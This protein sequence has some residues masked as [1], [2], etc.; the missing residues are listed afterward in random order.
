[1]RK[2]ELPDEGVSPVIGVMLMIV[3][4]IIIAAVVSAFA[5]GLSGGQ[6]K[7]PV[8]QFEMHYF[9]HLMDESTTFAESYTVG[10][11]TYKGIG[12][13]GYSQFTVSLKSGEPIP[14]WDLKLVFTKTLKDGT[15]LRHEYGKGSRAA[16]HAGDHDLFR[17]SGNGRY[18]DQSGV[19]I[20]PGEVFRAYDSNG[21]SSVLGQDVSDN[22]SGLGD[23]FDV[24]VVH[25]P[26][27]TIISHQAVTIE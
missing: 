23:S 26:T 20:H 18:W 19:I 21:L 25:V 8:A 2:R 13:G 7:V 1:M 12:S 22:L 5:G 16:G 6:D 10:G 15:I 27:N 17:D 11:E 3:V 9:S 24:D 4:T 14:T